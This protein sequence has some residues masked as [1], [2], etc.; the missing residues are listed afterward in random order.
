MW[1]RL[2]DTGPASSL[3][4]TT[5]PAVVPAIHRWLIAQCTADVAG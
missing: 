5:M 1:L 4:H 2:S 3:L